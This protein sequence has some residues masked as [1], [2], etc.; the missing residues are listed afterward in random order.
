METYFSL[1]HQ[2][3]GCSGG[4]RM[5]M[6]SRPTKACERTRNPDDSRRPRRMT[7]WWGSS[8]TAS[9]KKHKRDRSQSLIVDFVKS[10]LSYKLKRGE[11]SKFRVRVSPRRR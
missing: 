6:D 9:T 2:T 8:E 5:R 4:T 3:D 10:L 11:L 7:S 1:L